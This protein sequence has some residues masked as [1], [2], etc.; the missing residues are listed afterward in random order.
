[1]KKGCV[2]N[3]DGGCKFG[4]EAHGV[5]MSVADFVQPWTG[6]MKETKKKEVQSDRSTETDSSKGS[7]E[8]WP[9][10][11]GDLIDI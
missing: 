2:G 5:D 11:V 1:V 7:M 3:N 9:T 4:P 6:K 10:M 8:N